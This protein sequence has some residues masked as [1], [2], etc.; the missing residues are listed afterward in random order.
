MR[1]WATG[2]S[3]LALLLALTAPAMA[4]EP[5]IIP[6]LVPRDTGR[7][8]GAGYHDWMLSCAGGCHAFTRL[9][10]A[11][12]GAPEVLRLSVAPAGAEV[13]AL[14]LRTPAPLY[15]P[16]PLLLVPDRADPVEVPWFT[17]DPRG[18]EARLT[19]GEALVDALRAGRSANV[20]LTLV[21]GAKVRLPLSLRGFT[22]ALAAAARLAPGDGTPERAGPPAPVSP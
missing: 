12:E 9:R 16:A 10:S 1:S 2:T 20:E 8:V 13:Y 6:P 3:A 19:A 5:P 22:A 21:D 18:C 17:C 14:T 11:A 7:L 4:G 15:L